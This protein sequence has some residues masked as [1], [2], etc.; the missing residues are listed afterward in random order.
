MPRTLLGKATVCVGRD[1]ELALLE[2]TF[3]ECV[4]EPVARAVLVTAAAGGG[5]SRLRHE[6]VER[7][8]RHE[9]RSSSS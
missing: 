9:R 5:K 3:E 8:R 6:L 7:L 2:G 1:R 4:D